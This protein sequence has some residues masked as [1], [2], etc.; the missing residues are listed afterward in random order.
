MKF[1]RADDGSYAR[2][3]TR[4]LDLARVHIRRAAGSNIAGGCGLRS[5]PKGCSSSTASSCRPPARLRGR[6]VGAA[7]IHS[8]T[9]AFHVI[10]ARATIVCTNAMTFRSG[11]VRDITGTGTLLAYRAGA[12]LQCR[13]Q[14]RAA[15]HPQ[16]LFRRHHLRDPGRRAFRQ[17]Q[18][19]GVHARIR[20][21]L[22]GRG[23]RSAHRMALEDK[24]NDPLYLDMSVI[25]EGMREYFIQSKVKWM[26]YFFRKLGRSAHRH[27]RQDAVLRAQSDD[28]DGDPHRAGL[29]GRRPG[30]AG[31]RA[32]QAGCAN[33]FAG[34]HIGLCN[35][36]GWAAGRSA[37][38]DLDRLPPPRL[39]AA[40]IQLLHDDT[41]RPLQAA[42]VAESNRILRDLQAVMFAYDVGILKS[43]ER[44]QRALREVE[45]LDQQFRDLAAPTHPELVRLKETEA[46]LLAARF[47]LG[48]S[49][50]RTDRGSAISAKTT[51][52]ATTQLAGVD[53]CLARRQPARVHQDAGSDPA[54]PGP[55]P[56]GPPDA[57]EPALGSRRQLA[58]VAQ[59]RAIQEDHDPAI[60]HS[61][62]LGGGVGRASPRRRA[63]DFP[64]RPITIMVGLAPGGITDVTARLYAEAVSEA[65]GSASSSRTARA[66]ARRWPRRRCRT[67]RRT[68]TRCWCSQDRSTRPCR[69]CNRRPMIRSRG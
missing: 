66:P 54:V 36:N 37:I 27:V 38:E 69:P 10:K 24:G 4:G 2:R 29:P 48:A 40:V 33:H 21:G 46:M 13:V 7:G 30:P 52:S 26:D 25:P 32:A 61:I 14:L 68:D 3:P 28:Q 22:G 8:R 63:Q 47:I 12:A 45:A 19:R 41:M 15:G 34:F 11:F 44:L 62:G 18:G 57:V 31:G 64:S 6:I 53:R 59:Y 20:A 1:H 67:P 5:K 9:G 60:F 58:H 16:V 49:L 50:L 56:A 65:S 17:C 23:R 39:D 43:A 42:A 51:R 55:D 35:G